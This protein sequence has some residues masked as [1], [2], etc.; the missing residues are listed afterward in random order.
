MA[1]K[2]QHYL[3]RF[4]LKGFASRTE[5]KKAFT[6]YFR[7]D[8]KPIEVSIRDV[9]LEKSFYDNSGAG[10]IDK[11]I[12]EKEQLFGDLLSRIRRDLHIQS[13]DFNL[14]AEFIV[15]LTSRT[16][17]VRTGF[18]NGFAKLTNM[19]SRNL[20][21]PQ[22][23]KRFIKGLIKN[24]KK[25]HEQIRIKIREDLGRPIPDIED[26]II[27]LIEENVDIVTDEI[28]GPSLLLAEQ[29]FSQP[30]QNIEQIGESSHKKALMQLLPEIERSKRFD[31]YYGLK[32]NIVQSNPGSLV[33]GDVGVMEI[34]PKLNEIYPAIISMLPEGVVLLPISTD[35]LLVGSTNSDISLPSLTTLNYG[36][37]ELSA[38]F[39]V[40]SVNSEKEMLCL[41]GIGTRSDFLKNSEVDELEKRRFGKEH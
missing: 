19:V 25:F 1:G 21:E 17:H 5:G 8:T 38:E 33:L 37:V 7:K 27:N 34:D 39:F 12:T 29:L 35:C 3:P 24:D 4:L 22:Q 31:R 14:L 15:H 6:W 40:S 26:L 2:R 11:I 30:K 20:S 41:K 23:I 10:S 32:W 13:K 36:S 18:T 9:G 28:T 16:K